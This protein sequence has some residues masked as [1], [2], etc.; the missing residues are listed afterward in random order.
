MSDKATISIT[1]RCSQSQETPCPVG[2]S[3]AQPISITATAPVAKVTYSKAGGR[4]P[5][6]TESWC[7]CQAKRMPP[8]TK[9]PTANGAASRAAKLSKLTDI[10]KVKIGKSVV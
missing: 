3:N 10:H 5:L 9:V 7:A 8:I 1:L 2:L 6:D 4:N